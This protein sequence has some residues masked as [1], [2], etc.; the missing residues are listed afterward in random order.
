MFDMGFAPQVNRILES[1]TD[2]RQTMLFSAT[3]PALVEKIVSSHLRAPVRIEIARSGSTPENI[4]QKIEHVEKSDKVTVLDALLRSQEGSA[5]LFVR[6]KFGAKKLCTELKRR[7]HSAAEIHSDRTLAQRRAALDGFKQGQK[8]ILVAT[9]IAAR[10]ID[11]SGVAFVVNYDMPE[12][13][14]DYI[15]RIG[16]TGRAGSPGHAISFVQRDQRQLLRRVEQLTGHALAPQALKERGDTR[17]ASS[18][19]SARTRGFRKKTSYTPS[20][21]FKKSHQ[22]APVKKTAVR[23]I[24]K[25]KW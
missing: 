8:R 25:K 3:M 10:G 16:R 6:T 11:V 22:R 14:E 2:E 17:S 1:L 18:S 15:H 13:P 19:N 5:I 24:T 9:D 21:G 23:Y 7:N 4:T 12:N 20:Y